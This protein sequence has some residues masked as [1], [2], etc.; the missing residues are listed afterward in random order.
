MFRSAADAAVHETI[1][2]LLT[3]KGLRALTEDER[4]PIFR[5]FI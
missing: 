1:D 4:K 3:A 5:K 2:G